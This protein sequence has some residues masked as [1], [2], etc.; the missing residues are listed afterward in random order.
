MG[1]FPAL[2]MSWLGQVPTSFG[3]GWLVS[4]G[5]P[6]AFAL[7]LLMSLAISLDMANRA[8]LGGGKF[9]GLSALMAVLLTVVSFTPWMVALKKD[10]KSGGAKAFPISGL[11]FALVTLAF[12][13]GFNMGDKM[14]GLQG[15]LITLMYVFIVGSIGYNGAQAKVNPSAKGQTLYMLMLFLLLAMFDVSG[16]LRGGGTKEANKNLGGASAQELNSLRNSLEEASKQA[17][18]NKE[19]ANLLRTEASKNPELVT[20]VGA[21]NVKAAASAKKAQEALEA[22]KTAQGN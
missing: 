8:G 21:A 14:G 16:A 17:K 9:Y 18:I 19:A 6:A 12:S 1:A 7:I 13:I 10:P 20:Q 3:A 11:L 5:K 4:Q 15:G 2:I 22:L